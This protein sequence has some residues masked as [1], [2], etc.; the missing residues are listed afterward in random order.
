MNTTVKQST[1]VA[2][3]A[4]VVTEA[5]SAKVVTEAKS[6]KVVTEAKSAKVKTEKKPTQWTK[7]LEANK[8]YKIE[9]RSLGYVLKNLVKTES[10]DID[11]VILNELVKIESDSTLYKA[12]KLFVE[13]QKNFKG[14]YSR[15]NVLRF[16]YSR[17]K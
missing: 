1:K 10:K 14:G 15:F 5:K 16:V 11:K 12:C 7:I 6:A 3:S 2:K 13:S 17:I 4:K 8:A 9:E